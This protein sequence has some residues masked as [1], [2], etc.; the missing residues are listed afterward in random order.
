MGFDIKQ[1]VI[2][3]DLNKA[4]SIPF[5]SMRKRATSVI[6]H[7]KDLNKFRVFCKGAPEIVLNFCSSYLNKENEAIELDSEKKQELI[8]KIVT[9]EFASKA[10][11][12]ILISYRD[13]TKEEFDQLREE[14]EDFKT[15]QS[16]E[17]LEKDLTALAI[18]AIA[19]PLRPEVVHAIQM[20]KEAGITVRMVTGDN[21]HTAKAIA[22]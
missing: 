8:D 16:R 12:T 7:P 2:D 5:N 9:E 18:F 1:M 20:C 22:V 21:I 19:D 17:V 13:Y 6:Q 10:Y 4:C 11:R 15:P 14:N 3:R